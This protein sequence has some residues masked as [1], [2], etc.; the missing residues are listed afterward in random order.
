MQGT[1]GNRG[2]EWAGSNLLSGVVLWS[3]DKASSYLFHP[4]VIWKLLVLL[5][6]PV[7]SREQPEQLPTGSTARERES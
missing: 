1:R 2:G 3:N 5:Y 6:P 7:V 4:Q